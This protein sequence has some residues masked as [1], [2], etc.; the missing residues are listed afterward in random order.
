MEVHGGGGGV[1]TNNEAC[2]GAL[3]FDDVPR[4]YIVY[5][6]Y[7]IINQQGETR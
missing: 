2:T 3:V 4:F 1:V 5:N 6:S 7:A